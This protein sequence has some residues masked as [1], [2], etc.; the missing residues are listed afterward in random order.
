MRNRGSGAR[1]FMTELMFSIFFFI[2]VSAICV[3]CF[4]TAYAKSREAKDLTKAVNLATNTAEVFL[5][6][7]DFDDFTVVYD[8]DWNETG[9]DGSYKLTAIVTEPESGASCKTLQVVV[10][11]SDDEPIYTLKV[12]KAVK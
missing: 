3:Q 4:A 9:T 2:V 12:E 5:A 8:E 10:C 11:Q 7:E 6:K 1:I